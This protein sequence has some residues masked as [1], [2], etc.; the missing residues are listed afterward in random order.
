MNWRRLLGSLLIP[1]A[2]YLYLMALLAIERFWPWLL[3]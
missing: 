2:L 3:R 1:I